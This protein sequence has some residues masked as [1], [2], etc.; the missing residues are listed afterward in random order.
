MIG[1]VRLLP[2]RELAHLPAT[3]FSAASLALKPGRAAVADVAGEEIMA[4]HAVLDVSR[5]KR[6]D[7]AARPGPRVL[8]R[9]AGGFAAGTKHFVD[10]GAGDR[11]VSLR[12]RPRAL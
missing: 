11:K 8:P 12:P 6:R 2:G 5:C 4:G 10:R 1:V 9:D 3:R 7:C